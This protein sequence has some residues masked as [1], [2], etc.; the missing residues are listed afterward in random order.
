MDNQ[1]E[2]NSLDQTI[3][4]NQVTS[5]VINKELPYI[6]VEEMFNTPEYDAYV[7]S[8]DLAVIQEMAQIEPL[9]NK[10]GSGAYGNMAVDRPTLASDTFDPVVQQNPLNKNDPEY[11]NR[12]MEM[13]ADLLLG[14][15]EPGRGIVAPKYAGIRQEKFQRY[16]NHPQFN[17]LGF[18]P[19]SDME[20]TYNANS[21]IYDDYTRM[22]GQFSSL[23]GTGF[24]SGY[25]AIGD[26]FQGDYIAP[27]LESADEFADAMAIGNSS[28]EGGM[29]WTNNML[30][31][32]GYTIG[33]ISSIAVEEV[34]LAA[35]AGF[36]GGLNPVSDAML[37]T[38]TARNIGRLKKLGS[39]VANSFNVT[40]MANQTRNMVKT[41][42]QA[43]N[44]RDFWSMQKGAT[45]GGA[46]AFFAPETVAAIRNL[47]TTANGTQNMVNL[48]KQST[49][50]GGFY[51]DARSLN[52][53][54]AESK[55][56]GGMVY[57][58]M[59][60]EGSNILS[61]ENYGQPVTPEQMINI[62]DKASRAAFKTTI[63]N[64]PLIFATN[65]LVLGTAFGGFNKSFGRMVNDK[66]SDVGRRILKTK[67]VANPFKDA[68]TGIKG[69]WN[70]FVNA[71][72]KGN[73]KKSASTGLR[74]FAANFGEGIQEVSQEAV[75]AGTKGYYTALLTDP[76][77]G[78]IDLFKENLNSAVSSQF[79][80]QG[81]DTFMSGFLMGG[82]VSV[83]QKIFFQGIPAIYK[84]ASDPKAY[85]EHKANRK[86]YV[87]SI[88][89][90]YNEINELNKNDVGAV[91]DQKKFQF[92]TVLWIKQK[93]FK[94][95]VKNE[96]TRLHRFEI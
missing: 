2:N 79:S 57:N 34:A 26:F 20:T 90:S 59:V 11:F 49:V 43:D 68:G 18:T 8:A 82:V 36:Q 64:A 66:V 78:G 6:P 4:D 21:T 96:T 47:K 62:E 46:L 72:V 28:R 86:T 17:K 48:A 22:W 63:I 55:L 53:A 75:S 51:R 15:D 23:A 74:Y 84:R 35:A 95:S 31:N 45:A 27:D 42:N 80:A 24:V 85:A 89:K 1:L 3:K 40:R 77:A 19:Y 7:D 25:R 91:F 76:L 54:I 5:G 33:I 92:L 88:I 87:D 93:K 13:P 12:L 9:I 14:G 37:L 50:F 83:P 94:K 58:D 81:F 44:A 67:A 38:A 29:A 70:S 73:L 65:Q 69:V 30:L 60:R 71:G 56:E 39:T 52:L 32:S 61:R 16:Y 10:Y 41:F